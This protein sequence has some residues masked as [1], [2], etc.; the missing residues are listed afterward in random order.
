MKLLLLDNFMTLD[1]VQSLNSVIPSLE[2]VAVTWNFALPS[3]VFATEGEIRVQ[4]SYLPKLSTQKLAPVAPIGR[5]ENCS[6]M[7]CRSTQKKE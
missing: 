3:R 5:G 6:T 2:L 4:T 1:F 7:R